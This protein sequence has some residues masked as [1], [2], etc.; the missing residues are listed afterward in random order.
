M[1]G[2][3]QDALDVLDAESPADQ[4][5]KTC[6]QVSKT[7]VFETYFDTLTPQPTTPHKMRPCRPYLLAGKCMKSW[8]LDA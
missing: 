3:F 8:P 7:Q 5:S 1:V 2:V 4:V 6:H